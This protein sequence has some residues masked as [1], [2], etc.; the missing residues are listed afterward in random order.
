MVQTIAECKFGAFGAIVRLQDL[1]RFNTEKG[2]ALDAYALAVYACML[3]IRRDYPDRIVS[4]IFDRIER[5]FSRLEKATEYA[6][7]DPTYPGAADFI[8]PIPLPAACTFRNVRPIQAADFLVWEIRKHHV[9]Q[10]EWWELQDRPDGWNQRFEHY[11][12]WSERRFGTKLPPARKSFG[13]LMG[14]MQLNGI[15]FDYRGLCL[16][17]EATGGIWS[18]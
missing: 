13:A 10:N 5:V 12:A 1:A 17:H 7:G 11:K 2:L 8:Q 16:A 4:L 18:L 9:Q 6:K 15:I 14:Q 3:Q